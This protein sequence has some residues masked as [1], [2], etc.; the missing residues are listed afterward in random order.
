MKSATAREARWTRTVA[1]P[2]AVSTAWILPTHV[3]WSTGSHHGRETGQAD[4]GA[5]TTSAATAT[6]ATIRSF[7][8]LFLL[9]ST[10]GTAR[11]VRR[12]NARGAAHPNAG[13]MA[14]PSTGDRGP[15]AVL[16]S[17]VRQDVLR[18]RWV[19]GGGR[20]RGSGRPVG[21]VWRSAQH[22]D[23]A[24]GD[25]A[26][27]GEARLVDG[28]RRRAPEAL[29]G[30]HEEYAAGIYNLAL[31]VVRHPSDAE[32]ITQDVLI[33]AFERLPKDREVL[34]RPWLYRLTLNRCYDYLRVAARRPLAAAPEQEAPSPHDLFDQSELQRLL[35]AS[36]G[37]LTRRQ[38][39]ALLLKDVHGLTLV[40]VG[41]CLDLTPGSVEVLLARARR[42]FRASFEGRCVA[43]GRPV[44]RSAGALVGL[45]LLPLPAALGAPP[46]APLFAP[47]VAAPTPAPFVPI[48]P[49]VGA[50]LTAAT[51]TGGGIGALLG[52]P[53]SVK[54]AVLVAAAAASLG[55]AE[56]VATRADQRPPR[57][58]ARAAVESAAVT[59][60]VTATAAGPR[61][62]AASSVVE[63]AAKSSS[64][65]PAPLTPSATAT[66]TATAEPSPQGSPLAIPTPV[67]TPDGS[68][69]PTPDAH[70]TTSASP[71]PYPFAVSHPDRHTECGPEPV[72]LALTA[73]RRPRLPPFSD[74]L[75]GHAPRTPPARHC[76]ASPTVSTPAI[77]VR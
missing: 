63:A 67:T 5:A 13:A 40:E 30:L 49:A 53:A 55:S 36:L 4:A 71:S 7:L 19:A 3:K 17:G 66:A 47:P 68:P 16:G 10:A 22:E 38:R 70:A 75:G 12:S 25:V 42:A 37:D 28:L 26:R 72:A 65:S 69:S 77:W 51:A 62:G 20:L 41:A 31:R 2:A 48:G 44:P 18:Q 32:D 74:P 1:V 15:G 43:A 56:L 33:R 27:P 59:H 61:E 23:D 64:P 9:G 11:V 35:E 21:K 29:A 45:P 39:A 14:A 58:E 73:P 60:A 6:R 54:T 24:R 50:P 34:L 57:P 76:P 52:L 46:L 8:I